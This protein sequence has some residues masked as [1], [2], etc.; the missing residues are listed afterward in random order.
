MVNEKH[1]IIESLL[2]RELNSAKISSIKLTQNI[3][4]HFCDR[5]V[6]DSRE[7]YI[8]LK[9]VYK[10]T[11]M[12]VDFNRSSDLT[13]FINLLKGSAEYLKEMHYQDLLV[14]RSGEPEHSLMKYWDQLV[15]RKQLKLIEEIISIYE[16]E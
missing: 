11:V 5:F 12:Q 3:S 4:N 2:K 8:N 9:M 16:E 15:N 14:S 7:L 10:L 13:Y 6:W 1:Q